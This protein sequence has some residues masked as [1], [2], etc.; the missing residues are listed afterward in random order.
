MNESKHGSVPAAGNSPAAIDELKHTR[1]LDAY[2]DMLNVLKNKYLIVLCLKNTSGQAI[3]EAAAEK[4]RSL[5]F[6]GF[7]AEPD[8]KYV[9]V[10]GNSSVVRDISSAADEQ[11]LSFELSVSK[12]KV[13]ISFEEKEAEIKIGGKDHSLNDKGINIVVYDLKKSEVVDVSCCNMSEGRPEFYHRNLYCDEQ[14]ID[15]HIYIPEN[16]KDVA[17]L[18]IRRSYFSPRSLNVR[19]V[20]RGIFLPTQLVYEPDEETDETFHKVPHLR[21]YGGVCDENLNCIAGH[22]LLNPRNIS[23]ENRNIWGSYDVQPENITYIDETVLYGG[24]L[25]E[26]PG[27]LIAECFAD[28][29]WWIAENADS[30]IKIAVEII[31]SKS[32]LTSGGISFVREF[33]DALGISE[34]RII[35][36]EKPTQF[37]KMIVPDQ[38]AIPLNYCFPYDFTSGF[39]KPFQ[40][41]TKRLAPGKYKKI[42]LTKSKATKNNIIGEEYFIDF[43]E[44]KG[45]KIIHP[46]DHTVKE[47]AELMYGA[48]EVVTIDGTS[49]LFTVFCKPSVR[50]T[51]LTRRTECWN[52]PQQLINEALGIKEFFL[53]NI[54]GSFLDSSADGDVFNNYAL[55]MMLACA[56]KEFARYVKY[57]Y[58]EDLDITP[59]ES[60][61]KYSY[62]YLARF[63]EYYSQPIYFSIVNNIKITDILRNMSEVF[64]GKELDTSG[65]YFV[66]DDE[67]DIKKLKIQLQ[68]EKETNA[69][70]IKQLSEKAKEYIEGNVGLKQAIAQLESENQ[71]LREKNSELSSYMAEISSLLDALEAQGAP[72]E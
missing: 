8:M 55:G 60:L 43:F 69:E 71:K 9:G 20:E 41:I 52:T 68:E 16:H 21:S 66:T 42:Y 47:K 35:V 6:S 57:V 3:S 39:I 58:N 29:L 15:T 22:Q 14:Y 53:V 67:H 56:T 13:F 45:F 54:S 7:T 27:H 31:W 32:P 37:K 59:E 48:D 49:S 1:Y 23:M 28:R 72:E 38:S 44:K 5:G 50:L 70:K 62:D 61:K 11:P 63:P 10:I 46:E 51:V 34:D 26:H 33:L 12:T 17:A 30:D 65:L 25:I 36:I 2:L 24:T 4:I 19:E 64:W 40:H 18:P